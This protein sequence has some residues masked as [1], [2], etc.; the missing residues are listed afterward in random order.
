M[1]NS[2][3]VVALLF[4]SLL[5][6]S[7]CSSP[8]SQVGGVDVDLTTLNTNMIFSQVSQILNNPEEYMGQ[9][10]KIRGQ[11]YALY[12]EP[13]EKYYYYVTVCD[14]TACCFQALEFLW[15]DGTPVYPDDY[16]IDKA[17]I[18]VTG[19]FEAYKD[20]TDATYYRLATEDVI[21]I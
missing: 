15:D 20:S 6:T 10:I 16:P 19:I 1:K 17:L 13:E 11:F 2:R 18:E 14:S 8:A 12:H 5:L 4:I 3:V 9:S 21:V 7:G